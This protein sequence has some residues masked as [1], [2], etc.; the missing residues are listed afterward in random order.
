[1]TNN[2]YT[3]TQSLAPILAGYGDLLSVADL[4]EIFKI[5]KT[6]AYKGIKDG[7]FGTPIKIG[8]AFLF[9]K[10]HIISRFFAA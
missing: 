7:K 5:S 4:A 6:T 10:V 3:S 1:M 2:S 8:R 9:P